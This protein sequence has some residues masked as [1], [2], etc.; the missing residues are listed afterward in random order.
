MK[1]KPQLA[2]SLLG[3]AFLMGAIANADVAAPNSL[4]VFGWASTNGGTTGGHGADAAH[5]YTVAS[6][7]ELIMALYPDAVMAPDG[8]WTS[9]A[10]ADA[11]PK[12]IYIKGTINLS[13]N[14]AG[15]ELTYEDYQD[16]AYDFQAYVDTY[17]PS[18]WNANPA[19]WDAATNR[20][21]S[22][23]GP[24]EAARQ[25]SS[26]NQARIINIPVGSNTSLI[27]L[28]HNA[29]IV[30]GQIQ[31]RNVTNVVIRNIT[32]EDSFDMF[33]E[34]DPRDSFVLDTTKAGCQATFV[35]ASTGPH[36]CPGGRWNTDFDNVQVHNAQNVW[37]DHCTFTDGNREDWKYPSVFEPPHVG[38]D[39]LVVRHD[40]ALDVT[41][42]SD[43]VT[44]SHNHFR[45]HDKTNLLGSS[46]TATV[47]NGW[48]A[49]S[50]TVAYNRYD[51][52]GQRLPR[53]RFGKVH[54][55]NNYYS[56]HIGYLGQYAP[57]DGSVVPKNRFLYGI[58]IGNLAKIYAENNVFE[59]KDA[60]GNG[61]AV[62]DSVM[63]FNWYGANQVINGVLEKTYFYD[64]G[65][66]LNGEPRSIFDAA[67]ATAVTQ[68]KPPLE[69]TPTIWAPSTNYSY[70]LLPS[71]DVEKYVRQNAGAGKL[72]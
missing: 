67:Q 4:G 42:T 64:V 22:L 69:S 50:V 26:N 8:S 48:G 61:P 41:G 11:T 38:Y 32:F 17:K 1:W 63:F 68:G 39:Y 9:A 29:R 31:V 65:T 58:G 16:P 51:D 62:D 2:A 49:L 28:G 6:R 45:N 59:I 7:R 71:S 44:I 34:W 33:P 23:S 13:E 47:A 43:F 37:I 72:K 35:D 15:K 21:R 30:K 5:I 55:Y 18:V 66:I 14:V 19:N 10:G 3:V 25:R 53:V 40:G 57:T 36:K 56:G 54:V 12:I 52:A 27:G 46:N 20:P 70:V 60:P 24:L